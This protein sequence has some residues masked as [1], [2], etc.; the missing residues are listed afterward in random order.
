MNIT[1]VKAERKSLNSVEVTYGIEGTEFSVEWN[2][3][4]AGT[5]E[6]GYYDLQLNTKS[7]DTLLAE[8]VD[9]TIKAGESYANDD[10][11]LYL[12]V[13]DTFTNIDCLD[14]GLPFLEIL[15]QEEYDANY[16]GN[17]RYLSALGGCSDYGHKEDVG[18][19]DWM[20]Q[21]EVEV[22]NKDLETKIFTVAFQPCERLNSM[23]N[24][25]GYEITTANKYGYDADKYDELIEFCDYDET[26]IDQLYDIA[27]EAAREEFSRLLELLKNDEI[28]VRGSRAIGGDV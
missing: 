3:I 26:I 20:Y 22:T 11:E 17:D 18:L 13:R 28:S 2:N 21:F 19:A 6:I 14:F 16:Y 25:F 12:Y 4:H 1:F 24:Y 7:I 5:G 23:R 8:R 10:I 27:I 9:N 15:S